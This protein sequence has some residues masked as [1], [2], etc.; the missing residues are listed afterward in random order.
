MKV[1]AVIFVY[2]LISALQYIQFILKT[3]SQEF[4]V[5]AEQLYESLLR[6]RK[7]KERDIDM[8]EQPILVFPK[9][10]HE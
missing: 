4:W 5:E 9:E 1:L 7:K 10:A 3:N 2:K 8:A 6:K